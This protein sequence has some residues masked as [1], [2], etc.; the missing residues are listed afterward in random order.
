ML[1]YKNRKKTVY[2][3]IETMIYYFLDEYVCINH[4]RLYQE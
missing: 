2:K 3:V 1:F 4:L